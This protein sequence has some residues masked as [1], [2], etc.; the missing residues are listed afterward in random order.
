[1]RLTEKT[2]QSIHLDL[3]GLS[4]RQPTKTQSVP[5]FKRLMDTLEA[6]AQL[7]PTLESQA[8]QSTKGVTQEKNNTL[9]DIKTAIKRLCNVMIGHAFLEKKVV[10]EA[11]LTA[12]RSRFA[13]ARE[14]EVSAVAKEVI[15]ETRK[16]VVYWI[17]F[18]ITEADLVGV[19]AQIT[20]FDEQAP[21]GK[22]IKSE[23]KKAVANRT[24]V[25]KTSGVTK[26]HILHI[27]SAF[28]GVDDEFYGDILEALKI[29]P[30]KRTSAARIKVVLLS[31]ATQKP[32]M[33]RMV[34]VLEAEQTATSNK[35]GEILFKF[36]T[37]GVHTIEV[38]LPNGEIKTVKDVEAVL[39]KTK[40]LTILI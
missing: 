17:D 39:G 40:T 29:R 36:K 15:A 26:K 38:L 7:V 14:S 19:E 5:A 25:F 28:I 4:K 3:I 34:R 23:K 2:K 31:V 27:A 21:K 18:G 10:L 20:L 12:L 9:F 33:D 13:A 16:L 30:R 24:K 11:D 35:K 8:Q 32:M 37:A 22:V 1:M 6:D